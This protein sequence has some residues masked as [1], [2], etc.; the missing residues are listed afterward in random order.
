M[1]AG[2]AEP[3]WQ[4]EDVQ[5]RQGRRL[6]PAEP[7]TLDIPAGRV[8]VL[9]LS[10]AGK[11]SLLNALAG[12]TQPER[13]SI[14]GPSVIAWVPQDHG[15]WLAHSAIEHLVLAGATSAVARQLLA[16]FDLAHRESA[17]ADALSI[18][19]GARLAVARPPQPIHS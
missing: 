7:L 17:R 11:T 6:W 3:P 10:G 14:R 13:G 15:L 5:I 4:L 18:G 1:R 16:G 12:F 8:A 2:S 19:E 9:G